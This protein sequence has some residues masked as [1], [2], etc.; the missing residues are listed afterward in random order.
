M[1][2]PATLVNAHKKNRLA[3]AYLFY[4]LGTDKYREPVLE[5]FRTICC[6]QTSE[7]NC[8]SCQDCKQITG[9]SHPDL[10]ALEADQQKI[11]VKMVREQIVEPASLTSVQ[12]DRLF[13]WLND[14][15]RLTPAA[16]NALLKVLEEPPGE[17][18]FVLTARTRWECLPTIRS[19]CQW[20]RFKPQ[21]E[22]PADVEATLNS[23]WPEIE[24][25]SEQL[26]TWRR[27]LGG[28]TT[29]DQVNWT[30]EK[31]RHF[32]GFLLAV[33]HQCYTNGQVNEEYAELADERDLS[34]RLL[35]LILQRLD[36]LERGAKPLLTVNSLLEEIY[37]PEEQQEWLNVI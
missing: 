20:T 25:D 27:L 21:T 22:I 9:L 10:V 4:G 12:S 2:L 5:F 24:I 13:F 3:H 30:R 18:I 15:Q 31:A 19:R 7:G 28:K 36:E 23:F 8:G 32:L 26:E 11:S 37:Y 33:I 35:P 1:K 14:I 6:E 29:S 34:Y 16:S 17:A